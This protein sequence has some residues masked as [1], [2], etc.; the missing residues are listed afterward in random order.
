MVDPLIDPGEWR[1]LT[2][3]QKHRVAILKPETTMDQARAIIE[4]F[5]NPHKDRG[6][7]AHITAKIELGEQ[8]SLVVHAMC[9]RDT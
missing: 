4:S 3:H 9:Y 8:V 1:T 7:K 5:G 2:S 6:G